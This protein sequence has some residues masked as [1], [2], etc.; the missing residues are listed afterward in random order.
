MVTITKPT[1]RFI[2]YL[3]HSVTID[4]V[5]YKPEPPRSLKPKQ[6]IVL[7]VPD[8]VFAMSMRKDLAV[9]HNGKLVTH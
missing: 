8:N 3:S 6:G 7:I 9:F 1:P 5:E 4:G 2:N